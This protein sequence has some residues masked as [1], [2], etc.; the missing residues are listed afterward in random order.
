MW[1]IIVIHK[2]GLLIILL[3]K[4]RRLLGKGV[5]LNN[6]LLWF[7]LIF[8]QLWLGLSCILLR[9]DLLSRWISL[10]RRSLLLGRNNWLRWASC[11]YVMLVKYSVRKL[12]LENIFIEERFDSSGNYGSFEDLIDVRSSLYINS[13]HLTHK[14][15]KFS[16]KMRGEWGILTLYNLYSKEMNVT[17]IEGWL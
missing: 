2:L 8:I 6:W 5:W 17:S 12:I 15:L 3:S 1:D 11:H 16:A 10:K 13:Q 7:I 4:R 14:C 9:N